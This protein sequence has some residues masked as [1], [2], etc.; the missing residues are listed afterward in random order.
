[1]SECSRRSDTLLMLATHECQVYTCVCV[2]G[3]G[4]IARCVIVYSTCMYD[5]NA[6]MCVGV[7]SMRAHVFDLQITTRDIE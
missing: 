2:G 4:T 5:V 7:Y 1:M 6:F 3:K